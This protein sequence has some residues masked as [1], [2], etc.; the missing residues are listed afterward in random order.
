MI[1]DVITLVIAGA[2]LVVSALALRWAKVSAK[3]SQLSADV[4][5]R[6]EAARAESV[7]EAS[8]RW[9]MT[10][11]ADEVSARNLGPRPAYEVSIA[12]SSPNEGGTTPVLLE[13]CAEVLPGGA[14]AFDVAQHDHVLHPWVQVSWKLDPADHEWR[15]YKVPLPERPSQRVV[16]LS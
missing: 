10:R 4:A 14:Y 12:L 7:A 9:E 1:S 6:A 13:T 15:K 3:A 2:A 8:V 16:I 11:R 5:A